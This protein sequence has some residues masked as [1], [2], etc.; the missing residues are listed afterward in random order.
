MRTDSFDAFTRTSTV[1]AGQGARVI[2][3]QAITSVSGDG[4]IV[5]S[6]IGDLDRGELAAVAVQIRDVITGLASLI[7]VS[8]LDSLPTGGAGTFFQLRGWELAHEYL[9]GIGIE[10]ADLCCEACLQM[11]TT[12][13]ASIAAGLALAGGMESLPA[14]RAPELGYGEG[15]VVPDPRGNERQVP[16]GRPDAAPSGAHPYLADTPTMHVHGA[17]PMPPYPSPR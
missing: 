13:L 12:S 15:A 5:L 14:P 16:E 17:G 10:P 7:G 6:A 1:T 9:A 8:P 2:I 11:M 4:C 3:N